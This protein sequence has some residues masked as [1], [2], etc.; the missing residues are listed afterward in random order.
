MGIEKYSNRDFVIINGVRIEHLCK[1]CVNRDT[2]WRARLNC[3][4]TY[5]V[6]YQPIPEFVLKEEKKNAEG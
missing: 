3:V 2:N 4:K 6:D 1:S 5:C